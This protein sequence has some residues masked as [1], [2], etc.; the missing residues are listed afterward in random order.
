MQKVLISYKAINQLRPSTLE[1][2]ITSQTKISSLRAVIHSQFS[3]EPSEQ[4]LIY[5]PDENHIPSS[6]HRLIEDTDI[7]VKIVPPGGTIHIIK[8]GS[9]LVFLY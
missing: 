3:I 2:N 4:V 5:D 8:K 9:Y 6:N 7:I 1:C